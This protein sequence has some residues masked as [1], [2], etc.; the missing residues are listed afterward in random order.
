MQHTGIEI[1]IVVMYILL[2]VQVSIDT[3]VFDTI[4]SVKPLFKNQRCAREMCSEF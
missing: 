3:A 1:Y 2:D 4:F